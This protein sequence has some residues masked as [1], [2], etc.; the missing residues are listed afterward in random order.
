MS[1]R[2]WMRGDGQKPRAIFH[3][4][5]FSFYLSIEKQR[6][7]QECLTYGLKLS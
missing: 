1:V 6:V 3:L 2:R 7:R 5:S 4:S